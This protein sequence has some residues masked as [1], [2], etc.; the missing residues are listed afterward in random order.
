[1]AIDSNNSV[2]I[3]IES[4]YILPSLFAVCVRGRCCL[5]LD[6]SVASR[7]SFFSKRGHNVRIASD[8]RFIRRCYAPGLDHRGIPTNRRDHDSIFRRAKD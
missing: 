8:V 4:C 3:R 7:G 5:M 2:S 1:M 6:Y